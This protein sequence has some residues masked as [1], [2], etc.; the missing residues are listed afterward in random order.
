[1][2]KTVN[3]KG[4]YSIILKPT[5]D[6]RFGRFG[7]QK[8]SR[9]PCTFERRVNRDRN[10]ET[11]SY[12]VWVY[13]QIFCVKF[14]GFP[15]K[16]IFAVFYPPRKIRKDTEANLCPSVKSVDNKPYKK[17]V[18]FICLIILRQKSFQ[19]ENSPGKKRFCAKNAFSKFSCNS[20]KFSG[21]PKNRFLQF[22]IHHGKRGKTRKR[23]C[24]HLWIK[25][26]IFWC[27]AV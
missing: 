18:I 23:I 27:A 3:H 7:G 13:P 24:V 21:F 16:P 10:P 26:R 22:F 1:M 6:S 9:F 20:V 17:S 25:P 5:K 8:V 14:S 2:V 11:L 4:F 19:N 12:P 15:K